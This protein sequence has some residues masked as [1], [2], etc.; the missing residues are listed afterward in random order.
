MNNRNRVPT[1]LVLIATLVFFAAAGWL[2]ILEKI[3]K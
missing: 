3:H 1:T 2:A